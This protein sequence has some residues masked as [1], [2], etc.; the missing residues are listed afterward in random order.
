MKALKQIIDDDYEDIR[1]RSDSQS[2]FSPKVERVHLQSEVLK[3]SNSL[4]MTIYE[5]PKEASA[6]EMENNNDSSYHR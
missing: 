2:S 4:L 3:H 6:S 5:K 1:L